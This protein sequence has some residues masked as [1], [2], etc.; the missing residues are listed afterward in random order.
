ML[1]TFLGLYLTVNYYFLIRIRTPLHD[2]FWSAEPSLETVEMVA[3]QDPTLFHLTDTRGALPLSYVRRE[4]W[5]IWIGF[6][7]AHKDQ[8]WPI[9][10]E[11]QRR[12]RLSPLI[13]EAPNSRPLPDPKNALSLELVQMVVSGALSLRE[14]KLLEAEGATETCDSDSDEDTESEDDEDDDDSDCSESNEVSST[15]DDENLTSF[16]DLGFSAQDM[17]QM[18]SVIESTSVKKRGQ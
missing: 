1:L 18:L 9:L 14:A 6:L 4:H 12:E 8:W 15:D 11:Q 10:T 5:N 3:N 16:E 7:E 13:E 17:S 2:A